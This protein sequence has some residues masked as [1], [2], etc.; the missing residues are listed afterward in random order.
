[1]PPV[2]FQNEAFMCSMKIEATD[3]AADWSWGKLFLKPT[4]L[5]ASVRAEPPLSKRQATKLPQ[6]GKAQLAEPRSKEYRHFVNKLLL[7]NHSQDYLLDEKLRKKEAKLRQLRR[8][9]ADPKV[10]RAL[11]AANSIETSS[12]PLIMN[13]KS[14][15]KLLQISKT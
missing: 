10:F 9:S 11:A 14:P 3:A 6:I 8:E 13:H 15:Q 5:M 7:K 1:M 2:R 4:S 12:T